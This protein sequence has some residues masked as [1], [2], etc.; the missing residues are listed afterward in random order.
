MC[1]RLRIHRYLAAPLKI[2]DLLESYIKIFK[3]TYRILRCMKL[4]IVQDNF[5][6]IFIKS[7]KKSLEHRQHQ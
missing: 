5:I 4:K 1:T 2:V 7:L 6:S 3:E